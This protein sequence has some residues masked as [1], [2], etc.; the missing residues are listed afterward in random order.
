MNVKQA[1]K[2]FGGRSGVAKALGISYQAVRDWE[3][4]GKIPRG[5][6]FEIQVLSKGK[7]RASP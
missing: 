5:R 2:H 7:L 6:Q 3:E 1:I 4:N